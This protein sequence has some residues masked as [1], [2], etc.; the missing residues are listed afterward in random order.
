MIAIGD[1]R[2]MADKA[3]IDGTVLDKPKRNGS[4]VL[5]ECTDNEDGMISSDF[6]DVI[7]ALAV[8]R[9]GIHTSIDDVRLIIIP[10]SHMKQRKIW[11]KLDNSLKGQV[12]KG[13][14][15]V[16]TNPLPVPHG[17]GKPLRKLMKVEHNLTG[18]FKIRI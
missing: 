4:A 3:S 14:A 18:F 16:R 5:C 17:Y 15:K 13:I 1:Y 6:N 10:C 11:L 8:Y 9:Y 12:L 2:E 7:T